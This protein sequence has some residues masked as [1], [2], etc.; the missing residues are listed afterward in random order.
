MLWIGFISAPLAKSRNY[1]FPISRVLWQR[2]LPGR[3]AHAHVKR[4]VLR[5]RGKLYSHCAS[6]AR[7]GSDDSANDASFEAYFLH[8]DTFAPRFIALLTL[9]RSF[10]SEKRYQRMHA[11]PVSS[12]SR[13]RAAAMMSRDDISP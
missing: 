11:I 5:Q 8:A 1:D 2:A 13:F 6:D 10:R 12:R 7:K 4:P 9:A 3:Y